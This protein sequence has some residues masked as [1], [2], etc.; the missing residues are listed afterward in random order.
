MD[1]KYFLLMQGTEAHDQ[2]L[3]KVFGYAAI[4]RCK[5]PVD[6][7]T[8]VKCAE[9]LVHI[10]NKKSFLRELA[11]N[12]LL[13]LTGDHIHLCILASGER[14]ACVEHSAANALRLVACCTFIVSS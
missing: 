9:G 6:Q 7:E 4:V 14:T 13:D 10:A 11:A 12:V 2:M 5:R 8:A 3:G 1:G